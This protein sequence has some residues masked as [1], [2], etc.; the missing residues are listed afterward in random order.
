[1]RRIESILEAMEVELF[2]APFK[3]KSVSVL[4]A[5]RALRGELKA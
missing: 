1:M 3:E 4:R 5:L 2:S